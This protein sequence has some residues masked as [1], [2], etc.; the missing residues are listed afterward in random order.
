MRGYQARDWG[1]S[2]ATATCHCRANA[3]WQCDSFRIRS[4][5]IVQ[6]KEK[7]NYDVVIISG[8]ANFVPEKYL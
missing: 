2:G 7:K 1:S 3:Y 8:F 4:V 6:L 5:F